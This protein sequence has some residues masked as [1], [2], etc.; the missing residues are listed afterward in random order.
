M[1][2]YPIDP[3]IL[4]KRKAIPGLISELSYLNEDKAVNYIRIWG[5][6]RMPITELFDELINT[7]QAEKDNIK[8]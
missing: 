4:R 6:K 5:E 7:I 8:E 2:E 3:E 1:I